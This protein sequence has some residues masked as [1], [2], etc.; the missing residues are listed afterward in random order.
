MQPIAIYTICNALALAIY[1][2]E[3]GVNDK[4]LTGFVGPEKPGR[5]T[6][7]TIYTNAAGRMYF[8]KYGVKYYLDDFMRC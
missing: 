8:K 1:D 7:N 6:R 4:V 3:Y 2:I 5:K